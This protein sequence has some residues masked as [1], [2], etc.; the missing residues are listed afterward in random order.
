[1]I[2]IRTLPL[3]TMSIALYVALFH[4]YMYIKK[5]G[6]R[7]NLSFT[8]VCLYMF[9]LALICLM[10]YNVESFDG[11]VFWVK[12]FYVTFPLF[13]AAFIHFVYDF[14][15]QGSR[16]IPWMLTGFCGLEMFIMG[17]ISLFTSREKPVYIPVDFL[18][19]SYVSYRGGG[20]AE[21]MKTLVVFS[22]YLI[23]V[24]GFIMIVR[25]Y[26]AGNRAV[27]PIFI[28]A[29]L[30]FLC[31]INDTLIEARVYSFVFLAEYGGLFLI[32][33]MANALINQMVQT[34]QEMSQINVLSAIGK[35]ATEVVHD[36]TSPL[37]AIKLAASIAKQ[38]GS[39]DI[40]E[41]YLSLIE[42][43]T[44]R[45][46][47]LSFDI[48]QFVNNK[49]ALS[50]QT[51]DLKAYMQ[52]V[53]FLLQ[54][55]FTTHKI[56]F[57]SALDYDGPVSLD[58]DAFKRIIIN[59]ATNARESLSS[60]LAINPKPEFSIRVHKQAK[61]IVFTFSDNGPGIPDH[62]NEH[63]F[64]PFTTYG[65][66]FGTGLGL[67]ISKQIADRHGGTMTCHS[68]LHEGTSFCISL[69]DFK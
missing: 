58:P 2:L 26:R 16:K 35:M 42:S 67:A 23:I 41:K 19:F 25:S 12:L 28:G 63:I 17:A 68:I 4:A 43:E 22:A 56:G 61:H 34:H 6:N 53:C 39:P 69:P 27:R 40:Q 38:D 33:G 62:V 3:A 66:K 47:D 21:S 37:T 1:M 18:P 65:K 10:N 7:T 14:T 60:H 48:L 36:L 32:L 45:L 44:K 13:P 24:H 50:K 15:D 57:S 49:G 54:G 20:L 51:V 8:W 55:D 29:L 30:F 64:E 31:G 11:H 46:S 52:E 9:L 5:L 59:L